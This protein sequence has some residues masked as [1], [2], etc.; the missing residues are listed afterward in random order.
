MFYC[1]K[2]NIF[3]LI[4]QPHFIKVITQYKRIAES[5]RYSCQFQYKI[6]SVH[7]DSID[8]DIFR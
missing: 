4:T 5:I 3:L 6:I 2:R 7:F 8:F 1:N